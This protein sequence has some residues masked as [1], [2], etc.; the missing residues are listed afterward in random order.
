MNLA[1]S[2]IFTSLDL[3]SGYWQLAMHPE[4]IEKTAFVTQD[5]QWEW[6]VMPMGL[7]NAPSSF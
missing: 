1:G 3:R 5:G 7:T 6:L 2:T 4:S